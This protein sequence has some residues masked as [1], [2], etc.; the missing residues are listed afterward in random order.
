MISKEGRA[1]TPVPI[2]LPLPIMMHDFAITQRYALFMDLP[3]VLDTAS[4]ATKG[5]LPIVFDGSKESR[6]GILPRY[7]TSADAMLWF[8]VPTC[9]IFHNANAWEDGEDE[10]VLVACRYDSMDLFDFMNPPDT[11]G[12][13]L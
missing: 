2:P 9:F 8:T 3:L 11:F 1:G 10:V 7:A 4:L 13:F 6:I 12:A 5:T